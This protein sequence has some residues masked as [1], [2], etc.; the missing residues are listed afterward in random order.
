MFG[1]DDFDSESELEPSK[2]QSGAGEAWQKP[3]HAPAPAPAAAVRWITVS[4][5]LAGAT[6]VEWFEAVAIS[7]G[8]CETL[9]SSRISSGRI[10]SDGVAID[11]TGAVSVSVQKDGNVSAHE[12]VAAILR[13]LLG[14]QSVPTP[15]R[16][17]LSQSSTSNSIEEWASAIAYYERPNRSALIQAVFER[18]TTAGKALHTDVSSRAVVPP[19]PVPAPVPSPVPTLAA[20][21]PPAP[22]K[23]AS[24]NKGRR[25]LLTFRAA[26][27]LGIAAAAVAIFT[28][29]VWAV[30]EFGT[31]PAGAAAAAPPN[32]ATS[33]R[34]VATPSVVETLVNRLPV[35]GAKG[36]TWD[37]GEAV[38]N[39]PSGK[40]IRLYP[41]RPALQMSRIVMPVTRSFPIEIPQVIA[42]PVASSVVPRPP[43]PLFLKA[44]YSADDDDVVP[45]VA[46][47]PQ[48]PST[49]PP[50]IM[51]SDFAEFE[52]VVTPAGRVESVRA[53]RVPATMAEAVRVTLSLSAAKT[54]RF[55]PGTKDGEPVKYRQVIRILK[56]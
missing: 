13:A 5:L 41:E 55:R 39:L 50:G 35:I 27:M 8:I 46:I 56:N 49:F 44:I 23:S 33:A 24:A 10:L 42:E 34:T 28:A 37:E 6:P 20:A 19:V 22:A 21:E 51:P 26:A 40:W 47:Y 18:A 45:P 17:A 9:V 38:P 31:W 16:L 43:L 12:D 30:Q 15:L 25:G 2:G 1:I 3:Y 29:G 53:N 4:D 52:V 54:W 11:G 32:A 48:F 36:T 14:D 7:Q